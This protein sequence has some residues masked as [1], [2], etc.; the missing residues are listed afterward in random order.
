MQN[1]NGHKVDLYIP[2]KCA[3]TNRLIHAKDHASI[4]VNIALVDEAGLYTGETQTYALAGFLRGK[5][6]S[7]AAL[8]FLADRDGFVK[9]IQTLPP[10]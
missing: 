1:D 3:Y 8:N 7:D 2:R 4:Q 9:N 10:L 5:A 6:E